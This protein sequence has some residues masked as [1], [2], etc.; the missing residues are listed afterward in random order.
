MKSKPISHLPALHIWGPI[1]IAGIYLV[2]GIIWILFSDQIAAKLAPN[3]ATLTQISIYK[4]W[5]YVIVTAL[6]LHLLVRRYTVELNKTESSM[7]KNEKNYQEL[8]QNANSVILRWRRDGT[9]VFFNEYAQNFFGYNSEEIIGKN[10]G[11]LVPETESTGGDLSK[12]VEDVVLHPDRYTKFVNEN[13]CKNGQRAWMAWTNRPVYDE[14][15]Q[16]TEIMAVGVDITERKRAEELL[17][18]QHKQLLSFIEQAPLSTAMFDQNM[19]YLAASRRW[20]TD[21]GQGHTDLIGLNHYDIN[22]DVPDYWIEAHQ[23]GLNGQ[24]VKND[25]DVWQR[26]DGTKHWLRWA[27]TPW[28]DESGNTGGIIILAED[29]SERKRAEAAAFQSEMRY[30]RI[31]DAMLEGCQIIDFDWRY[32]YVNEVVALQG[33]RK[34][35]EL[36]GK[37]MMEM[38][39]GIENSELFKILQKCMADREPRHLEN[40]FDFPDGSV[41]CFELSIQPAQEGLFI[42]S[43][44]ITQRK[45]MENNLN[46]VLLNLEGAEEQAGLGSW[47]FDT[48]LNRGWWSKHM[49]QIFGLNPAQEIPSNEEYI[50]MIHPEDRELLL[51]TLFQ[52]SQGKPPK[53]QDF[54]TNPARGEMRIL[55]PK[56]RVETDP[57]GNVIK[58]SGTLLDI[59]AHR[60]NEDEI[61]RLNEELEERVIER[62]AQLRAANKELEAFSYSVS[63][64]LRAP[65]R[66]IDGFTQIL[67][68]DYQSLLGEEG[69]RVC[70]VISRETERM[71]HLIDDLLSFSRLGRKEMSTGHVNMQALAASAFNELTKEKERGRID[72]RLQALPPAVGDEALL[73]QVWI[74]LLS[75]AIKFSSKQE[76]AI[77]EVGCAMDEGDESVYYVRDN[78]AGFDM[79]YMNKLFGVFQRLHSE[80]EFEGTGVGLAIVQRVIHRHGGRVWAEGQVGAG[81]T[82]HFSLHGEERKDERN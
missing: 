31:L 77:I 43:T 57:S 42:L 6:L 76:R 17:E 18:Q 16:V 64:D 26:A 12:L 63:H 44:D 8:V 45:Q 28:I 15:G 7:V 14:A 56:Y 61:R 53:L 1:R 67:V 54:R 19:N 33:K 51:T 23:K 39:P 82:F 58:F 22:P 80:D 34:P 66:A 81:A 69:K 13:I 37:T 21:Y 71:G 48:Q 38:Y 59:T 10:V 32:V 79:E 27:I 72:L 4:G 20:A 50:E 70:T 73:R 55:S 25:D 74:N 68:E 47:F 40:R 11:I 3:P 75:N 78:G 24:S 5:G 9:I 29:I 49:Y 2:L 60:K 35:E 41:G 30:H 65:L 62:T 46:E 52:L 36:L